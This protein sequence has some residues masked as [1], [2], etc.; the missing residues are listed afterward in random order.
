M[1]TN[2][3]L[4]ITAVMMLVGSLVVSVAEGQFTYSMVYS[5]ACVSVQGRHEIESKIYI[6]QQYVHTHTYISTLNV[7]QLALDD[8]YAVHYAKT[9]AIR[10]A[11]SVHFRSMRLYIAYSSLQSILLRGRLKLNRTDTTIVLSNKSR[12]VYLERCLSR[13]TLCSLCFSLSVLHSM[14]HPTFE[15]LAHPSNI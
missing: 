7:S 8:H 6:Y 4:A 13:Q 2:S 12:Y 15:T 5:G 3:S 1:G 9:S 11:I 14:L 10:H